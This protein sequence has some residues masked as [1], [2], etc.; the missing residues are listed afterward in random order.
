MLIA[1]LDGEDEIPILFAQKHKRLFGRFDETDERLE[2]LLSERLDLIQ[3]HEEIVSTVIRQSSEVNCTK[4][5]K[6][7]FLVRQ[8]IES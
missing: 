3:L 6:C 4:S 5:V 1:L 2:V 8:L 7:F